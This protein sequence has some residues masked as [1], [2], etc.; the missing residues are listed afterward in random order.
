[1][2]YPSRQEDIGINSMQK[3]TRK[4]ICK[5]IRKRARVICELGYSLATWCGICSTAIAK[6]FRKYKYPA[7]I[8]DGSFLDNDHCWVES[9]GTIYDITATQFS[10]FSR[11]PL[12]IMK[13]EKA[14]HLFIAKKRYN[15]NSKKQMRSL[16]RG[17]PEDQ[18]PDKKLIKELTEGI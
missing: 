15:P 16:F 18:K 3:P 1:M 9:A 5:S 14:K 11:K 4:D 8:V 2:E 17:W 7:K 12:L 6:V 13:M 10:G